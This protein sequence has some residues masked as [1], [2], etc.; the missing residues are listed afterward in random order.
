VAKKIKLKTSKNQASVAAFIKSIEDEQLRKDCKTL[1][2]LFKDT[3]GLKPEM[4]GSSIIGF[5]EYTYHRANGDEGQFMATGFSPRK[6]GP[7]LY[8]MPGYTDFSKTLAKLGPHK[9]GKSCLYLR[10]LEGIDLKVVAQLIQAG[11]KD[12]KKKHETNF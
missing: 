2:K 8:I 9:L 1:L 3:T 7:T 5:G 6:S 11:L 10:S 4:W 12:L